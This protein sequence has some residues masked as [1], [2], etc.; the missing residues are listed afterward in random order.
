MK[1]FHKAIIA[2]LFI[3]L[4]PCVCA[5]TQVS[6]TSLSSPDGK[7]CIL[8]STRQSKLQYEVS[9]KGKLFIFPSKRCYH[10]FVGTI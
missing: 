2:S 4:S 9:V 3:F 7:L 5:W 10:L 8:F 6:L 1:I